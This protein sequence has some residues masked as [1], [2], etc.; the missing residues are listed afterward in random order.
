MDASVSAAPVVGVAPEWS[1][2]FG[3]R[4]PGEGVDDGRQWS[5]ALCLAKR[6]RLTT[7]SFIGYQA[8]MLV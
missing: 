3:S 1:L 7:D 4:R 8:G 6:G 5:Y 2:C